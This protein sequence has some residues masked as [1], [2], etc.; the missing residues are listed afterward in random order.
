MDCQNRKAICFSPSG[1]VNWKKII[2]KEF[3]NDYIVIKSAVVGHTWYGAIMEDITGEVH[4]YVVRVSVT[5]KR[6]NGFYVELRYKCKIMSE[7]GCPYSVRCPES[8]LKILSPTKNENANR[9]RFRCMEYH[10]RRK[11][12]SHTFCNWFLE[13]V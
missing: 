5:S 9:W 2:D 7:V 13:V 10:K 4:A 1:K 3:D 12:I 11:S 6:Q 8:I